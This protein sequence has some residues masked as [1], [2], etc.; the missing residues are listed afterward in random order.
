[1]PKVKEKSKS[2]GSPPCP[3]T[4][5]SHIQ[6]DSDPCTDDIIEDYGQS[7]V[8]SD[9]SNEMFQDCIVIDIENHSNNST[10]IAQNSDEEA[11]CSHW[12]EI[13]NV[14]DTEIHKT[15]KTIKGRWHERYS[16]DPEYREKEKQ[17]TRER[18]RTNMAYRK[19]HIKRV[20][21]NR[22]KHYVD[23]T[24]INIIKSQANTKAKRR[25]QTDKA[26]KN[27]KKIQA[28]AA[29]K[30]RYDTDMAHKI[31][32][33]TKDKSRKKNR[34]DTNDA[35][36]HAKKTQAK[37]TAKHR[38]YTNEAHKIAK[39]TKDKARKKSRY[40]TDN[41]HKT[42]K[43]NTDKARKKSRYDTDN[44][45]KTAKKNTDKARKKSRYDTDNVHKTAKKNTDKARKK[46]RYDT[47]NVH[48]TAKKNTDKARKRSRYDTDN[49][50]KTAK[51][52][53]DKARKKSRYD[54]DNVH[55]TA[56][57]NTDKARKKSRYDT[58]NVHKTAKKNTDKARKKSRYD[59]DT[60]Y[61]TKK[62]KSTNASQKQKYHTND[63]YRNMTIRK[64]GQLRARQ[65]VQKADFD[66]AN[67]KFQETCKEAPCHI[68][69]SCLRILFRQQVQYCHEVS[70]K[71][72]TIANE[73]ITKKYL[74]E[75]SDECKQECDI[76][77]SPRGRLWICFTCHRHI[78]NGKL[79]PE[80][81]ANGLELEDIPDV[82]SSTNVLEKQLIALRIAFGK[83]VNLPSGS[84]R[85]VRG[86][87]VNVPANI[88]HT[89]DTLP[90]PIHDA[91]IISVKLKR[92]LVYKSFCE[93]QLVDVTKLQL[94]LAILKDM[95]PLYKDI[96]IGTDDIANE[97]NAGLVAMTEK[98]RQACYDTSTDEYY[99]EQLCYDASTDDYDGNSD[100]SS[101]LHNNSN[102]TKSI[103]AND[104]E[105]VQILNDNIS[106]EE[107]NPD[108]HNTGNNDELTG[109]G[110]DT[111]LQ[112]VDLRDE[113]LANYD[114]MI[115]NVAPGENQKPVSVF[116]EDNGEAMAF[117]VQFP[118]GQNT[119]KSERQ[120][121]LSPS[122]YFN[123]RLLNVDTR[124]A[125]DTQYIFFAQYLT[126]LSQMTSSISIAMRQ[127]GAKTRDGRKVTADML[128]D[129]DQL[130]TIVNS[131]QGFRFMQSLR[132]S[133]QYWK[134]TMN[135]LFAMLRQLSLPTFFAT[136][137]CAEL[138]RWPEV[139]EAI[140]EQEGKTIDFESLTWQEKCAIIRKNP[141]TAVRMFDHRV[142]AFIKDIICGPSNPIGEV[143]DYFYRVEFQQ[144]G[145][146]HIHCLFWIKDAPAFDKDSDQTVTSFID[147]Y[148]SCQLPD[149]NTDPELRDIVKS[150]Q[151][152]R[153]KHSKSCKKGKKECRFNYPKPP[154]KDTIII[155]PHTN[156]TEINDH[157]EDKEKAKLTEK[158]LKVREY[159]KEQIDTESDS[160]L[161]SAGFDNYD[162]YINALRTVT[163]KSYVH[164]K[165]ETDDAWVNNYNPQ[166]L[167]CW[168][169]NMDIQYVT[170]PYSCIMY[171]VSYIS[172]GESELSEI[173]TQA[174]AEINEGN[175][176]VK[177]QMKKLAYIYF[178][179][180][181]MSVQEAVVRV[182]GL[183]L[184][185][186][187][188]DVKFIATDENATRMS[189]PLAQIKA[190][191]QAEGTD[192]NIWVPN[193]TDKYKARPVTEEFD[194]I[195]LASFVS[196]FRIIGNQTSER[197]NANVFT[198]QNNLGQIQR[199]T[200]GK[201]AVIRFAKFS[202]TKNSEKY[203]MSL[204]KL[205]LPYRI[206]KHLKPTSYETYQTFY[207][208]GA[209]SLTDQSEVIPVHC[210]VEEN[211][212]LFEKSDEELHDA[213]QL[214]QNS[215]SLQDAWAVIAPETECA[216]LQDEIDR[217]VDNTNGEDETTADD[218]PELCR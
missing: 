107:I 8:P 101:S 98:Q 111:C 211:R 123:A 112:P 143:V 44:V 10:C 201:P 45:H 104:L 122:K 49:V 172:K 109:V 48:K 127:G 11:G 134:Q 155:R 100:Q 66:I 215:D 198:L 78:A 179:N 42:A 154:A 178:T 59:T 185:D 136:F 199:R 194:K 1:M 82:L 80:S 50:H 125:S 118:T 79:P 166:L 114:D 46:S 70:Y 161:A 131:D 209:V 36:N 212:K 205:Y 21:A 57:K 173:L 214:L 84:Q 144:R 158:L 86:P 15:K 105:N 9:G 162:D 197:I 29:A 113:A 31:V 24:H 190:K 37:A 89:I 206:D 97:E 168:N 88:E 164:M 208:E 77:N 182:T 140:I 5:E 83:F 132:G 146:P 119:L 20:T 157:D 67:E 191:S 145:A 167:K 52:N 71:N 7:D 204:L 96:T 16:N 142:K 159:L 180:R 203:Y 160:Y 91:Q 183:R 116:R 19:A 63:T 103:C 169:A 202:P 170:D 85:G 200:R 196:D 32:K 129:K 43:K 13:S 138:S 189:I 30:L 92:K 3:E 213:W 121:K 106:V 34:Y 148:I 156:V 93:F 137:S 58:D 35:Y 177:R 130:R 33:K 139:I 90:R 124:F 188:R 28:K 181:E 25:Y 108:N 176:D 69:C 87:I 149:E 40:D 216:R 23:K 120:V 141:V 4:K 2:K 61:V 41:V 12:N 147:K 117:P 54:T 65:N 133:P 152:H 218:I 135:E 94:C 175:D 115:Y 195:C 39:K 151:M 74:H 174:R 55:K 64:S 81:H 51:K 95:N 47:D 53:T 99:A 38:Y 165:R 217:D 75:C 210:I 68:C 62:K 76:A 17:R 60:A 102:I 171:I 110:L 26:Y 14:S 18:Y 184:K 187:S 163:Q 73:A 207:M 22:G 6:V 153:K 128:A 192:S 150:V 126:E 193:I 27:A 72:R 186:C 56:K